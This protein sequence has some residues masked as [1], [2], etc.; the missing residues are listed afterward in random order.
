MARIT[1]RDSMMF[2][3]SSALASAGHQTGDLSASVAAPPQQWKYISPREAIR[4]RYFPDVVLQTQENRKVRLYEDLIKDRVMLINF[5][6][7]SCDR[8]CPRVVHNL[9]KV[10][11]LLGDRVG[12]DVFFYSFT[13]DPKHDTPK[14][15]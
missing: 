5:M 12:R 9:A 15:L 11:K 6:Y 10:Q 13:L 8:I 3:A 4:M 7:A 2:L 1:R 14:V